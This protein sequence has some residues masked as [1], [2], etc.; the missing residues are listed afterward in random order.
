MQPKGN[1]TRL[2]D[3]WA[4][5]MRSHGDA[6]QADPTIGANKV[7]NINIAPSV[8]GGYYGYSG[9]YGSGGPGLHCRAYLTAAQTALR[10]GEP[11]PKVD[12]ATM[13]RFSECMRATGIS[14][15]PDPTAGG[16]LTFSVGAGGDLN[17]S[18]PTFRNASKL[19]SKRTGAHVPG[20]G[21]TPPP[22]TIEIDGGP[23]G[24]ANG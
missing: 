14:D 8:Q 10:G 1:P 11:P 9:E 21:G 15:F 18:S 3:G 13:L 2:L 5:C 19:C 16:G 12:Q 24:G 22:G 4:A 6:N 20:S 7:I 23:P 17:P